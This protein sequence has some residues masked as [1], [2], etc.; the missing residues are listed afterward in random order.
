MAAQSTQ[1]TPSAPAPASGSNRHP[2]ASVPNA[3]GI[4]PGD[5][6]VVKSMTDPAGMSWVSYSPNGSSYLKA[7][8]TFNVYSVDDYMGATFI[9]Y[10]SP[11]GRCF[12]GYNLQCVPVDLVEKLTATGVSMTGAVATGNLIYNPPSTGSPFIVS[13]NQFIGSHTYTSGPLAAPSASPA[14]P[15]C[16]CRSLLWGHERD[17][18]FFKK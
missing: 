11:G 9:V 15:E 13:G 3:K 2:P 5:A 16:K 7:G 12:A 1:S 10:H 17:C 18:P 4:V 14:E 6:V 8:D